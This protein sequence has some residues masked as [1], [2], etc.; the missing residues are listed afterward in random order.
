MPLPPASRRVRLAAFFGLRRSI[1]GML[2][3]VVLVGLGERL[4]ERF[5]PVY[6][7]ALGGGVLSVGLLNGLDNLLSAVYAFFGGALADRLGIKRSLLLFD[8][9]A[10]AG[11]LVVILVP[12]W[13]AVLAGAVLFLSWS[14][15][16]LPATMA[17]IFRD[18]PG[19]QRVMGVSVHS[20]TRRVPM[21]LGPILG[22]LAIDSLGIERGIRAAF[23]AALL[24]AAV[25]AA[26]QARLIEA[27]PAGPE[28]PPGGRRRL[29]DPRGLWDRLPPPLK[30]LLL[31]D[32]LVRFCEQV[33]Y[34]FVVLWA[35]QEIAAPVSATEFG[36]LTAVEMATALLVYVPVARWADR[37]HKKPFVLATFAFFTLFPILLLAARSFWP[38]LGAFVVRGLKEFGEPTRKALILE[39]A[40]ETEKAA[41]FGLYYLVRD[42]IVAV[43]AFAG[44][45]LWAIGPIVNLLT[46]A[47][48][49]LAGTL[50]YACKGGD[51]RTP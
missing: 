8:L 28:P 3:M 26:L 33:P 50:W 41:T 18:L 9:V 34:A 42:L 43:A 6:L 7:M 23:A 11:Y 20:L 49:G 45:L 13:Q 31:A 36:L 47:A 17:L 4:A 21:A 22:G 15:I 38:L 12:A 39:L 1:V 2:A 32:I 24:L 16:S 35:L 30:R 40:P 37:S 29:G 25:A 5:L 14:A 46:A 51:E 19:T 10:M 27:D 44:A 48:C